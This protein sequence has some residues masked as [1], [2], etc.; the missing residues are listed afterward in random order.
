M[1][2]EY[3]TSVVRVTVFESDI[4]TVGL[5]EGNKVYVSGHF[6]TRFKKRGKA[7]T[8]YENITAETISTLGFVTGLTA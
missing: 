7:E 1:D 5:H 4:S 6:V 3:T 2:T 8:Y